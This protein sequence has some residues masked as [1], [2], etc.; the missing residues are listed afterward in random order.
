MFKGKDRLSCS[1]LFDEPNEV[2][3]ESRGWHTFEVTAPDTNGEIG[4]EDQWA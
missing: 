4:G 1:G 3:L 2:S